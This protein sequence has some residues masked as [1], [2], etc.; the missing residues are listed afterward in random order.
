[1]LFINSAQGIH[2]RENNANV[3]IKEWSREYRSDSLHRAILLKVA[4]F[5]GSE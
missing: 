2:Q 5:G 3:R 4:L 1:V